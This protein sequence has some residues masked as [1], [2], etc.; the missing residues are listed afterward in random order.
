M[1]KLMAVEL[2]YSARNLNYISDF[3][4]MVQAVIYSFTHSKVCTNL[5]GNFTPSGTYHTVRSWLHNLRGS[6]LVAPVQLI[7]HYFDNE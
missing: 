1:Q 5:I 7:E 6:G 3:C 2:L 4:S